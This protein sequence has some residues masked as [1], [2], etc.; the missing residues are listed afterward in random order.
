MEIIQDWGN[1]SQRDIIQHQ[2]KI[3]VG[4]LDSPFSF[5]TEK[6]QRWNQVVQVGPDRERRNPSRAL[7]SPFFNVT[8]VVMVF[9]LRA[10][11]I[12]GLHKVHKYLWVLFFFFLPETKGEKKNPTC[13][14]SFILHS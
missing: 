6:F 10:A 11:T 2:R 13:T 8:E 3:C 7:G 1:R 5:P 4:H 12:A 14:F 9:P